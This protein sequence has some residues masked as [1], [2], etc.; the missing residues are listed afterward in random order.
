MFNANAQV[1]VENNSKRSQELA[2]QKAIDSGSS[3]EEAVGKLNQADIEAHENKE[4][5]ELAKINYRLKNEVLTTEERDNLSLK[6]KGLTDALFSEG[7]DY[8]KFF[9]PA[10][11]RVVGA[12]KAEVINNGGGDA[13]N[14]STP[15]ELYLSKFKN[16][17]YDKL[18]KYNNKVLLEEQGY[19]KQGEELG[20]YY[21]G[22][23]VIRMGLKEAGF[24]PDSE[25]VFKQVPLNVITKYSHIPDKSN[26][27]YG[28]VRFAKGEIVPQDYNNKPYSDETEFVDYLQARRQQ[29]IDL[30]SKKEALWQTYHLNRDVASIEKGRIGQILGPA[31]ETFFGPTYTAENFPKT[32]QQIIDVFTNEVIPS[33]GIDPEKDLTEDQQRHIKKDIVD[34]GFETAGGLVGLTPY[35]VGLNKGQALLGVNRLI[36]GLSGARYIINGRNL[37]AAK[38]AQY[39]ASKGKTVKNMVDAG[40]ATKKA[41]SNWQ[42]FQALGLSLIHI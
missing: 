10:S 16:T 14:I 36:G 2:V 18:E 34:K 33:S 30:A 28:N 37:S 3:I 12:K 23:K 27:L 19:N 42:K 25:G 20:D 22:D 13:V 35:L 4:E 11:G 5:V 39:A 41:A 6:A 17:P 26:I 32:N 9:D 24:E 40:V 7:E 15:Y 8:N 31:A 1:E 29:K 21:V 38:A